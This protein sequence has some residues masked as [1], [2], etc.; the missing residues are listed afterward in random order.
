MRSPTLGVVA[1]LAESFDRDVSLAVF[2]RMCMVRHFEAGLIEA[3]K[4]KRVTV[5]VY[6][7]TGQESIAAAM[8][9]A[10][11]G[12]MI[13]AQHRCHA[14][15]LAFGG[16]PA[17]LRDELLC[18]P[19]GGSGGRAGSNC[20]QCHE[21]GVTMFGHHGLIGENVPMAVGAALGSGK[22]TVCFFGDGAAEEDYVFAAMG[23]AASH[24]LPVLFVCDDNDLSI[25]TPVSTRRT[26][27]LADVASAL[28][29]PAIDIADD[30]WTLLHETR[31]LSSDLPA[32]VN[33]RT[34]RARWHVGVGT[35]GP[36]EWD[37]FALVK[38]QLAELGLAGAAAEI[39]EDVQ[40]TMRSLW[41][42]SQ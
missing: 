32:L 4:E 2:R 18:L 41:R 28:G 42:D 12:Y 29:M 21:N 5:P 16:D 1:G 6:L 7:S 23:F 14:V 22:P 19:T 10:V 36:P 9:L 3:V 8:S 39:E 40:Q 37:R 17:K 13:F 24:K 38:E 35:D 30:P 15:Y 20:L 26:W 11:P 33:C 34:C 27:R 25:L 31:R